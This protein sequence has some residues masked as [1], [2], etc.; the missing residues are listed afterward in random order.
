MAVALLVRVGQAVQ[1]TFRARAAFSALLSL[2]ACARLGGARIAPAFVPPTFPEFARQPDMRPTI[3]S[4]RAGWPILPVD[5]SIYVD[6]EGYHLFYS[7]FFCRREHRRSY[8]W[9]PAD[10]TACDMGNTIT[11]IAYAFSRDRG[12]TWGFRQTPVVMSGDSGFDAARIE[13]A[14]AFRLGDTLYVAYSAD[15]DRDGRKFTARY[16][17]GVARL[18]LRRQSVR[19]AMMDESRQFE[20][21]ATPLLPFDLRTGHFDN[22]VQEPSVVIGPDGIVLYYIGLGL[23]LPGEPIDAAGQQI[24]SIGLGRAVLDEHLNVLVRSESALLEG[25]NTTEVKYFDHAYHLFASTLGGGDAHR[26][27]AISYATSA[28][29]AHWTTPTVILSPGSAPGFNDWGLMAPTAA[30]QLNRVVL[31]YTAFGTAPGECLLRG[32]D[33]RFGV[34]LVDV[35]RCMFVTIGRAVSA[36]PAVGPRA[37]NTNR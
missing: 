2:A 17:I 23:R 11:A 18:V 13:T 6:N 7:T 24:V 31:F 19:Q 35:S 25:V 9:D 20:R 8:S 27:E 28:D 32:R 29:G 1:P 36:L 10:P 5:P 30:V 15:G 37:N 14:A 21:R 16:Q 12:L 3:S 4:G 22:N 26:N 33:G 34:P